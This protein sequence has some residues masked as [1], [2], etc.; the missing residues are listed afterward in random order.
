MK[1]KNIFILLLMVSVLT[2]VMFCTGNSNHRYQYVNN[3]NISDKNGVPVGDSVWYFPESLFPNRIA[4][5]DSSDN[6]VNEI[7]IEPDTYLLTWYSEVL[8]E[9][10]EPLLYNFYLD[11]E[12]YRFTW[13]RSFHPDIV[14]RFERTNNHVT[15]TQKKFTEYVS[16]VEIEPNL[17][18]D[19]TDSTNMDETVKVVDLTHWNDFKKLILDNH[20][21]EMPTTVAW[22]MGTDGAEWILE[23]HTREGYHVVNR[24]TP[25]GQRHKEFKDICD[26]LI[27]LSDFSGEKNY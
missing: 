15:V 9:M 11:H 22:E 19:I 2:L 23:E 10:S 21:S 8:H 24:W 1:L 18:S 20:F 27:N 25:D 7:P 4:L 26:Y 5:M 3:I 16:M 12:V 14:I 6:E 13:L 17:Y